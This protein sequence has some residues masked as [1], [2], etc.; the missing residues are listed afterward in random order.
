MGE[1]EVEKP[2]PHRGGGEGLPKRQKRVLSAVL[3]KSMTGGASLG[4]EGAMSVSLAPPT[5]PRPPRAPGSS[6]LSQGP[7][8]SPAVLLPVCVAALLLPGGQPE[9]ALLA[10][11]HPGTGSLPSPLWC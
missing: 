9:P 1:R 11:L 7:I 10:S 8:L 3:L 6:R 5:T 4:T 2:S